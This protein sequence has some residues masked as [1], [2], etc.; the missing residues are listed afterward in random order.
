MAARMPDMDSWPDVLAMSAYA[1][2]PTP[3]IGT[4]VSLDAL[5]RGPAELMQ[6]MLTLSN[7][8]R[9]R[10][11]FMI[12][13]GEQK[14]AKPFGWKRGEGLKRLED[15]L[16]IFRRFWEED[17]PISFQGHFWELRDAW[18]GGR[19]TLPA[20]D[21]GA[22]RRAEAARSGDQLRRRVRHDGPAGRGEPGAMG[23]RGGG[24]PRIPRPVLRDPRCRSD[25]RPDG[26]P[27][28]RLIRPPAPGLT[29]PARPRCSRGTCARRYPGPGL[30]GRRPSSR[31][32]P[33]RL[34]RACRWGIGHDRW[35]QR[36]PGEMTDRPESNDAVQG[37]N[38]WVGVHHT[39]RRGP[40][41]R[42]RRHLDRR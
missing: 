19:E 3:G 5:R 24:V 11:I 1:V 16:Q 6:T 21:L 23:G 39:P 34:A 42:V 13:A 31:H 15:S 27:C 32:R 7:L 38:V 29:R 22:R 40:R 28:R 10:S 18:L 35:K 12:G 9:G 17:G 4:A 8:T 37:H 26:G 20:T 25:P 2:A 30:R 41:R 36:A 33:R 14:Q